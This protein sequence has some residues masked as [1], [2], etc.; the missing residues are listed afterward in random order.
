MPRKAGVLKLAG[1][2][3]DP[4]E[5]AAL[6]HLCSKGETGKKLWRNFVEAQCVGIGEILALYK[7]CRPSLDQLILACN[8]M[9]PRCYSVASSPL[10]SPE[11]I[12]IAFSIVKYECKLDIQSTE[13]VVLSRSDMNDP[14]IQTVDAVTTSIIE[15]IAIRRKGLA[16]AYFETIL[17]PWLYPETANSTAVPSAILLPLH[18]RVF[19]KPS[20]SFKLP[21]SV[22]YP[23]I[24]IGPGTGVAPFIG[25]LQ[26]RRAIECSRN[27]SKA[28]GVVAS[29]SPSERSGSKDCCMGEWRG[30]FEVDDLP[31]EETPLEKFLHS[32]PP[33]PIWLFFG[34][35]N[36][37]DFLYEVL[38][39]IIWHES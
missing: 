25:F 14:G 9:A 23:L 7:S 10:T 39:S 22:S 30:G 17:Q 1:C 38:K 27:N 6:K 13:T 12:S 16:T 26:H 20:I 36:Q 21:G 28:H 37:D 18:V 3:T 2:C 32:V 11:I 33:G 4:A 31:V 8:P 15:P 5:G 34:C 29:S 35:R 19:H 24:L